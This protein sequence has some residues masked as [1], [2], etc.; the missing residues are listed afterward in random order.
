MLDPIQRCHGQQKAPQVWQRGKRP[1][2]SIRVS[3]RGSQYL[4]KLIWPV[5]FYCQCTVSCIPVPHKHVFHPG[6]YLPLWRRFLVKRG[7]S[8]SIL[9]EQKWAQMHKHASYQDNRRS[10]PPRTDPLYTCC[11]DVI[12]DTIPCPSQEQSTLDKLPCVYP[13]DYYSSCCALV[14]KPNT[15]IKQW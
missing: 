2:E 7:W 6:I 5:T 13:T 4:E 1:H 11:P 10:T 14:L 9:Q 8:G 15:F 12:T 3:L